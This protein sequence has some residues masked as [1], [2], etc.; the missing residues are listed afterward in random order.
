MYEEVIVLIIRNYTEPIRVLCAGYRVLTLVRFG[1]GLAAD[2]LSLLESSVAGHLQDIL[3]GAWAAREKAIKLSRTIQRELRPLITSIIVADILCLIAS[4]S[5]VLAVENTF[6]RVR[7]V[8][9]TF[10]YLVSMLSLLYG[11]I[12]I[13]EKDEMTLEALQ[14]APLGGAVSVALD[15]SGFGR[16]TSTTVVSIFG[17]FVAFFCFLME[18]KDKSVEETQGETTDTSNGVLLN[19]SIEL[20]SPVFFTF[21]NAT[22]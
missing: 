17:A 14:E 19:A 8:G 21:D 7:L 6:Q 11:L 3:E 12:C 9:A 20:S 18:Q 5:E 22:K 2:C 10:L 16:V 13:T 1:D 15:L 4:V